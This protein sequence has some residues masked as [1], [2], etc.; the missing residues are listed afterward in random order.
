[1]A[2]KSPV[3]LH[4]I[5]LTMHHRGHAPSLIADMLGLHP[6]A[7]RGWLASQSC[8][9]FGERSRPGIQRP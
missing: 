3:E 8:I 2:R 9:G 7:L 5:A 4:R 1:M 6:G